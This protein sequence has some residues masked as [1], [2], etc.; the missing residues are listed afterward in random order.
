MRHSLARRAQRRKD[1]R[2]ESF[3]HWVG[4]QL[5]T[6]G[7]RSGGVNEY[8]IDFFAY[9]APP[10]SLRSVRGLKEGIDGVAGFLKQHAQA[11]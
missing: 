3:K 5:L 8:S 4:A 10:R 6:Q 11:A 9:S 2:G 1:R 7:G